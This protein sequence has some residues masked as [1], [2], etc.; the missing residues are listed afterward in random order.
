MQRPGNAVGQE[1]AEHDR[2]QQE[3]ERDARGELLLAVDHVEELVFG[4]PVGGGPVGAARHAE[5]LAGDDVAYALMDER[6]AD[7]LVCREHG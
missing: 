1:D 4:H 7:G 2:E 5:R 3:E 6:E